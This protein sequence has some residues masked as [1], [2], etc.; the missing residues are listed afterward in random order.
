MTPRQVAFGGLLAWAFLAFNAVR[1]WNVYDAHG[2]PCYGVV[3]G[4]RYGG[5]CFGPALRTGA[6]A[7]AIMAGAVIVLVLPAWLIARWWARRA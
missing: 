6:F 7:A 5:R 1:M 3:E 2:D 4:I